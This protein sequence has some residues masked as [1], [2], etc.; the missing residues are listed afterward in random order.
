MHKYLSIFTSWHLVFDYKLVIK[1]CIHASCTVLNIHKCLSSIT[2]YFGLYNTMNRCYNIITLNRSIN[3][4]KCLK[5]IIICVLAKWILYSR[6]ESNVVM[7]QSFNHIPVFHWG[8]TKFQQYLIVSHERF[9]HW[10]N[11]PKTN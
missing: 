10:V 11:L 4:A 5:Y 1:A 2:S 7:M 8:S 6:V 9:W 3:Y